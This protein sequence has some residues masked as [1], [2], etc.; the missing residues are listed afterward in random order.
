MTRSQ[1]RDPIGQAAEGCLPLCQ[2]RIHAARQRIPKNPPSKIAQTDC[3]A[4]GA[5]GSQRS[6]AYLAQGVFRGASR[7]CDG[8]H[9]ASVHRP[10]VPPRTP[11]GW[12][13]LFPYAASVM[14]RAW[15]PLREEG[16]FSLSSLD[17]AAPQWIWAKNGLGFFVDSLL[18]HRAGVADRAFWSPAGDTSAPAVEL[19]SATSGRIF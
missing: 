14:S 10:P 7:W 13:P 19:A 3:A 15:W 2:Q 4:T 12:W 9:S 5:K 16:L 18:K 6:G 11:R 8:R 1:A 17:H